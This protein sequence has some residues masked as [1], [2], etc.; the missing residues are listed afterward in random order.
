MDTLDVVI[1]TFIGLAAGLL[2]GLA[3]VG[4]SMVM[5]PGLG[6]VFGYTAAAGKPEQHLYAAAAM[7]VNVL[8]SLP[9]ALRHKKAGAVRFDVFKMLAPAMAVAIVVGVVI[10]NTFDGSVLKRALA[11]FILAYCAMNI[12]R[13]F[14]KRP[15][16]ERAAERLTPLRVLIVASVG[17]LTAGIL[18]LGGG[19][20]IV[21]MLQILCKMR[22]REAIATSLA[23][24]AVTAVIGAAVKIGTLPE[25]GQSIK[26]ALLYAAALG[27][28][29]ILGG[30]LGAGLNHRLPLGAVR[31]SISILL[32]LVA[33]K[34]LDL[35]PF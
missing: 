21:P 14:R 25:H 1:V 11:V 4:G 20:V 35:L 16:G 17:G 30:R 9:A 22:L 15:E 2:G 32:M 5:I 19:V 34:Q 24:M 27:P 6:L 29:A 8:V 7:L 23:T 28:G 26:T 10:S 31:I 13:V 12:Y 3:G 33:A 18:G